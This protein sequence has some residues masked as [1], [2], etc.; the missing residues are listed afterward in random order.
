[1][2]AEIEVATAV[3]FPEL[4]ATIDELVLHLTREKIALAVIRRLY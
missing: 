3:G 2:T 1:V 4:P